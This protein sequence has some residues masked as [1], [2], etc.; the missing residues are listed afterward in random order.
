MNAPAKPDQ[1]DPA[2]FADRLA[3]T[4]EPFPAS[5]K[6]YASG[7]VHADL[8]VPMREVSLTSGEAIALYDT[9][10]PY[11]ETSAAIDVR[12][13][14]AS[15]RGDWIDARDDTERYAGRAPQALDDGTKHEQ[16]EAQR[17]AALRR[18]AAALQR[19]PR[20]AKAGGNRSGNVTQMHYAR[21]GIVTPEMEYVALRENGK[22]EWM[23]EYLGDAGRERRLRGNPMGATLPAGPITPEFVRDEVARGRA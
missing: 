7:S 13:G 21:R 23:A 12:K 6:V 19:T 15:V 11:T 22:R 9:S 5:K 17:L 16:R 20:R 4:R 8:R 14:L 3:L 1:F 10:G 2:A 18:E